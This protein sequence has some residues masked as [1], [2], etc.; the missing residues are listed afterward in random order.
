MEISKDLNLVVPIERDDITLY[1]YSRPISR[2]VFENYHAV[3]SKAFSEL[4]DGGINVVAGVATASLAIRDAAKA[5]GIWDGDAGVE[6]GLFAEIRRTTMIYGPTDNGWHDMLIDDAV[7][8]GLIDEDEAR[9]AESAILFFT[10]ISRMFKKSMRKMVV[11]GMMQMAGC[12]TTSLGFTEW[13]DSL[14]I[15]TEAETS[16]E[17][18]EEVLT[19]IPA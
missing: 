14:E 19:I 6:K 9:E 5:K 1:A 13:H 18:K 12:A 17:K 16:A 15:L 11:T 3:L 4:T 10:L 2:V 7:K 8:R